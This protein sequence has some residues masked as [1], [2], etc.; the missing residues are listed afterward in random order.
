MNSAKI[1]ALTDLNLQLFERA[2]GPDIAALAVESFEN[3]AEIPA[4]IELLCVCGTD[5]LFATDSVVQKLE[6]LLATRPTRTL[7]LTLPAGV[8]TPHSVRFQSARNIDALAGRYSAT[9]EALTADEFTRYV[10]PVD[11]FDQRS[12]YLVASEHSFDFYDKVAAFVRKYG[13]YLLGTGYRAIIC[14]LDNT[15]W[16]GVF[17]EDYRNGD[18]YLPLPDTPEG[19]AFLDLQK[20]LKHAANSGLLLCI[21]SRNAHE[22]VRAFFAKNPSLSL[23]FEDFAVSAIGF[24]SKDKLVSSVLAGLAL[25]ERHVL[26]LDDS[27]HERSLV[28]AAFPELHVFD[29]PSDP[30]LLPARLRQEVGCIPKFHTREDSLRK[31]SIDSNAERARIRNE[32]AFG[33]EDWLSDLRSEVYVQPLHQEN[34]ARASQILNRTNQFHLSKRRLSQADLLKISKDKQIEICLYG[35]RDRIADEGLVGITISRLGTNHLEVS[36]FAMSCRVLGRRIEYA[37]LQSLVNRAGDKPVLMPNT[38]TD[39]LSAGSL[40]MK[41]ITD[42]VD[43]TVSSPSSFVLVDSRKAVLAATIKLIYPKR[44]DR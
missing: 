3:L 14:D 2:L 44:D 15:L 6:Y 20:E 40:F 18:D 33:I 28:S 31:M 27:P 13:S 9:L 36:D 34:L 39:K 29:F 16:D 43:D 5:S 38:D 10:E 32:S 42:N 1:L 25:S 41:E 21:A 37:L 11:F 30:L 17:A 12:R 4:S 7:L 35:Y 8:A 22:Q 23:K 24:E 19:R 26:F